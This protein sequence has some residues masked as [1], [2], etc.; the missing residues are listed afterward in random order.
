MAVEYWKKSIDKNKYIYSCDMLRLAFTI[1]EDS[2]GELRMHLCNP[3]KAYIKEF[4]INF[5]EFKYRNMWNLSY[6]SSTMTLGIGFNGTRKEQAFDGFIEFNPNKCMSDKLCSYDLAFILSRCVDVEV[7][8]YDL[9]IDIPYDRE[10]V[11]MRKD[12]RKYEL[13]QK[14]YADRTEYLG[15]RNNPGRVKLYNKQLESELDF[16]L[17]RLEITLGGLND[18]GV[19]LDKYLPEVW[20]DVSQKEIVFDLKDTDRVLCELI[21]DSADPEYYFR[22]LSYHMRKKLEPYIICGDAKLVFDTK[23]VESILTE[24]DKLV[25]YSCSGLI[26]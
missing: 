26:A 1:R 7:K 13:H 12:C 3:T 25:K 5:T 15:Q 14:S 19:Q 4:P 2:V 16:P 9:A 11:H 22:Q 8:R 21:R 17:T 23:C 6:G 18:I 10:L 20:T 24:I